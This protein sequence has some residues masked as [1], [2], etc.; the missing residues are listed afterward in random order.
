MYPTA[1][2]RTAASYQ[3]RFHP[4]MLSRNV[5]RHSCLSLFFVITQTE[6][7]FP[8]ATRVG[9][10]QFA[11]PLP[12]EILHRAFVFLRRRAR[13]ECAQVFPLARLRIFLAR[14]EAI[15]A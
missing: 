11:L 12:F 9:C 15:L 14:I 2:D 7:G 5:G 1:G 8:R 6:T 4:C 3:N 10:Q 13:I